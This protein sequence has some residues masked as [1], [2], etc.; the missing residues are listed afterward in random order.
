M[1]LNV[2]LLVL[3]FFSFF[4]EASVVKVYI[5]PHIHSQSRWFS[6]ET[7]IFQKTKVS[8]NFYK[9]K[10]DY[11]SKKFMSCLSLTKAMKGYH[12]F[13]RKWILNYRLKCAL[14]SN[15][16]AR[17]RAVLKEVHIKKIKNSS[18]YHIMAP[19]YI[20][21]GLR[22]LEYLLSKNRREAWVLGETL[23]QLKERMKKDEKFKFYLLM[24]ELAFIE[25]KNDLALSYLHRVSD[26]KVK[27]IFLKNLKKFEGLLKSY[28]P[29]GYDFFTLKQREEVVFYSEKEREIFEAFLK[30][31]QQ[32]NYVDSLQEGL[33]FLENFP[34]SQNGKKISKEMLKIYF[35]APKSY[36]A[37]ILKLFS[38]AY[39]H[40]R[41]QWA[42]EI[43]LKGD[44]KSTLTLIEGLRSSLEETTL[45]KKALFILAR[46]YYHLGHYRKSLRVYK[47]LINLESQKY[48]F[49]SLFKAGLLHYRLKEYEEA[50]NYFERLSQ[51]AEK[52][53]RVHLEDKAFYWLW[54][55][56]GKMKSRAVF[57]RRNRI[58]KSLLEKY[59]LSYYSLLVKGLTSQDKRLKKED[60]LQIKKQKLSLWLLSGQ[61]KDWSKIQFLIKVG[62]FEEAQAELN[63]WPKPFL[64]QE[65]IARGILRAQAFDYTKTSKY[66]Y[67]VFYKNPSFISLEL[68]SLIYPEEYKKTFQKMS[69]KYDL[70]YVWLLSLVRQE[71]H[72]DRKAVSSSQA[73]GLTQMIKMTAY[74]VKKDLKLKS[75][76][77]PEDLTDYKISLNFGAYYL[78]KLLKAQKGYLPFAVMAYNAGLGRVR[79]WLKARKNLWGDFQRQ[80]ISF[81]QMELLIEEIPWKQTRGYTKSILKNIILYKLIYKGYVD[82]KKPIWT[83]V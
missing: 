21:A 7:K 43:Y 69:R 67:D 15:N 54:K 1:V 56:L 61:S 28:F 18:V 60:L 14:G 63:A 66:F 50:V 74:E 38:K 25:Q 76:Q 64:D 4:V 10:K 49:D 2:V 83:E 32:K 57:E 30:Y 81:D 47:D 26:V 3:S 16:I 33:S 22:V 34:E 11:L 9:V 39:P 37:K 62:W 42:Y 48:I 46:S 52:K 35:K 65:K 78:K 73:V 53:K 44:F 40:W 41:L 59:P 17:M 29:Q 12:S 71:S 5:S 8:Y 77:F 82:F 75:F 58:K 13:Y 27:E 19:S 31:L 36:E 24:G 51:L 23:L 6:K 79:N 72:F 45:L 70:P 20:E 80:T 55:S 68:V